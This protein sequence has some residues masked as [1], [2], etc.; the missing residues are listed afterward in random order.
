MGIG[1]MTV[2]AQMRAQVAY[3]TDPHTDWT[4]CICAPRTSVTLPDVVLFTFREVIAAR[5]ITKV[6]KSKLARIEW[7]CRRLWVLGFTDLL[8]TKWEEQGGRGRGGK[9]RAEEGMRGN[10]EQRR[11]K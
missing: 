1:R 11:A 4:E 5:R 9:K 2:G 3:T 10:E 6:A 7:K 8:K